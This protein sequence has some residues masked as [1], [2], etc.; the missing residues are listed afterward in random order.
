MLKVPSGHCGHIDDFFKVI[1]QIQSGQTVPLKEGS[2]SVQIITNPD[3]GG[4]K[5][6]GSYGPGPDSV[7]LPKS[8]K[9]LKSYL[10]VIL[11]FSETTYQK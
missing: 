9:I 2:G 5:S 11:Y 1:M 4:Q 8:I 7:T 3:P 10:P 6:Y